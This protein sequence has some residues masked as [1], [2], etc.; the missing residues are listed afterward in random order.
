MSGKV[1]YRTREQ[2]SKRLIALSARKHHS[3]CEKNIGHTDKVLFE[4]SNNEGSITGFTGN[5]LRAEY[6]WKAGLAGRISTVKLTGI[7]GSGRMTLQL[8][9]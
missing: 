4:H 8:L 1:N 6:P 2:R 5:Y 3:F 9:D 7:S